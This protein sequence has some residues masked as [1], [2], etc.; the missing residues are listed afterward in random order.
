[1]STKR[2]KFLAPGTE[3]DT[4]IATGAI[5]HAD[6]FLPTDLRD[7]TVAELDPSQSGRFRLELQTALQGGAFSDEELANYGI[8][9]QTETERQWAM[10]E[11]EV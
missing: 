6:E 1:M 2:E 10:V 3:L 7:Q 5:G 9:I 11:A 4:H 8:G